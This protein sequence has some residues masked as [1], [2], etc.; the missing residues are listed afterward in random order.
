MKKTTFQALLIVTFAI[1]ACASLHQR[2][3]KVARNSDTIKAYENF[4][5]KYPDSK[6]KY[7]ANSRL[8]QL[9]EKQAKERKIKTEKLEMLFA[10]LK[11]YQPGNTAE[12][13]FL[14]DNWGPSNLFL[15]S[16]GTTYINDE[17]IDRTIYQ[18]G[19]T[20]IHNQK[21]A[22]SYESHFNLKNKFKGTGVEVQSQFNVWING[23]QKSVIGLTTA[24]C[25]VIFKKGILEKII[26]YNGQIEDFF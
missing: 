22:N 5:E 23:K 24:V 17:E 18:L 13:E 11:S 2:D 15:A 4:L 19:Y 1:C 25:A 14:S 12:T 20:G 7:E 10:K 9:E 16:I 21:L 8:K 6:Y 3:W 26:W